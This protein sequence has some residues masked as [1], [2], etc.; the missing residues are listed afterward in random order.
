MPLGGHVASNTICGSFSAVA[1]ADK[2]LA[3]ALELPEDDRARLALR[4]AESLE[5]PPEPTAR[6]RWAS[7][8]TR[9]IERLRDGT[10]KVVTAE[11]ALSAA[12]AAVASR[13]A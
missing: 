13:R 8:I 4:L 7:E 1:H 10:A 9:R 2:L 12:R 11:E 5:P 3:E 6:E